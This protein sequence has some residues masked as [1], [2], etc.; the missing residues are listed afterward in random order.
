MFEEWKHDPEFML[1]YQ[2]VRQKVLQHHYAHAK[3]G[4]GRGDYCADIEDCCRFSISLTEGYRTT[5]TNL[6]QAVDG[7][8]AVSVYYKY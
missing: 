2:S 7:A 1:K 4:K 3:T 5:L 6:D 8:R